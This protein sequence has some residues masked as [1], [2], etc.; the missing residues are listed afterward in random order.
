MQSQQDTKRVTAKQ[1]SQ[2]ARPQLSKWA[3]DKQ[4]VTEAIASFPKT[5]SLRAYKGTFSICPNA[6]YVNDSDDVQLVV[7]N[8][9]TNQELCK[10]YIAELSDE[11]VITDAAIIEVVKKQADQQNVH[12]SDAEALAIGKQNLPID[13][14]QRIADAFGIKYGVTADA[15]CTGCTVAGCEC[16][17]IPVEPSVT[18]KCGM[19][20][21]CIEPVT[22][23]D[24]KGF[25]YCVSC[26]AIRHNTHPVR[27]M[28]KWEIARLENGKTIWYERKSRLSYKDG[29]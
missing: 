23:I 11:I 3:Q 1:Q 29:E 7:I 12:L 20:H 13:R 25:L 26:A 19:K 9:D 15:P 2:S 10:G 5:F 27:A 18:L 16:G 21:G 8:A 17:L 4:R 24:N 14:E 28:R 6:S 22:H